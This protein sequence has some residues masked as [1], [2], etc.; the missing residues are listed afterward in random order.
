MKHI[1]KGNEP[2]EFT[3]W[4]ERVNDPENVGWRPSWD[5]FQ[6]PE[7]SVVHHSLMN[8]QGYICCYCMQRIDRASSHFEHIKPR[9]LSTQQNNEKEK[10]DYTNILA[11]CGRDDGK[12]ENMQEH[13][14][15]L[16]GRKGNWYNPALFVSPLNP[17]CE[18][19]FRFYDD[20][21]IRPAID[22]DEGAKRTIENLGLSHTLLEKNRR[23]V[24]EEAI[25]DLQILS[26][27]EIAQR[28]YEYTNRG[29]EGKFKEYCVAVQQSFK[30]QISSEILAQGNE[31]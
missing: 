23:V 14:G 16:R 4:K 13:C 27:D 3:H 19:R 31:Q 28:Y 9:E 30:R 6:N 15:Q 17:E 8:E 26:D 1:E 21:K 22:D 7:K 20:G 25:R 11:S 5:K 29:A 10:L 18:N 24:I 2:I 12:P